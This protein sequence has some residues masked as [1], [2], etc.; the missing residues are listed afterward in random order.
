MYGIF[1][2]E[3]LFNLSC[4]IIH[5]CMLRC[6]VWFLLYFKLRKKTIKK[7]FYSLIY[8]QVIPVAFYC[9]IQSNFV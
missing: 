8:F 3:E 1:Q 6:H 2:V 4:S 7:R 9:E 5:S